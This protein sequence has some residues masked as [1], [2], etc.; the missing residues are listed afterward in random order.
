MNDWQLHAS[1]GLLREMS[2]RGVFIELFD[3]KYAF[4]DLSIATGD[5]G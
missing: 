1:G 3:V 4:G 2:S 5:S